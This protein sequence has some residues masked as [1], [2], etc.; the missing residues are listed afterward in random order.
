[1]VVLGRTRGKGGRDNL[2]ESRGECAVKFD[3]VFNFSEG[4]DELGMQVEYNTDIYDGGFIERM[5]GHYRDLLGEATANRIRRSSISGFC[6]AER[7]ELLE[8]FNDTEAPYPSDKTIMGLFGEQV[9]RTPDR[10]AVVDE[11]EGGKATGSSM[12]GATS[13]VITCGSGGYGKRRWCRYAWT[14]RWR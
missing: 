9:E 5:I 11:G 2:G 4:G 8:A 1:M 13:W 14:G 3:M 12:S 10:V 7:R 6:R